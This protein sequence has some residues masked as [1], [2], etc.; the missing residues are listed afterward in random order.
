MPSSTSGRCIGRKRR[1][2]RAA[3]RSGN[4]GLVPLYL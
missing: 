4:D 2:R 1:Q 3:L